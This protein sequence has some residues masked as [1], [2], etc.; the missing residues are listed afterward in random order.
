MGRRTHLDEPR[1]LLGVGVEITR[2]AI[3]DFGHLLFAY[4]DDALCGAGQFRLV[5]KKNWKLVGGGKFLDNL[6]EI[7]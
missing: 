4:L 3:L 6:T 2:G 1:V 5:F 7:I